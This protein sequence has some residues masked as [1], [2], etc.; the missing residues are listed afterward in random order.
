MQHS[1]VTGA[2]KAIGKKSEP[3]KSKMFYENKHIRTTSH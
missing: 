2:R 3:R 1:L